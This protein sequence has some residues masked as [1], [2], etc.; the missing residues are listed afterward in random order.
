LAVPGRRVRV[1]A[2]IRLRWRVERERRSGGRV[3]DRDVR[4]YGRKA[5]RL[6]QAAVF[7]AE[8]AERPMNIGD[9]SLPKNVN[10]VGPDGPNPENPLKTAC[11][12][13]SRSEPFK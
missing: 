11:L 9:D 5:G 7:N 10:L 2:P 6:W 12:T 1:V 4:R 3:V 8:C 13:D